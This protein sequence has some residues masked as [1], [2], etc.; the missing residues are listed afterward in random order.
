MAFKKQYQR[1]MIHQ[2]IKKLKDLPAKKTK[3][4]KNSKRNKKINN[5]PRNGIRDYFYVNNTFFLLY[6]IR[7]GRTWFKGISQYLYYLL[8]YIKLT[9]CTTILFFSGIHFIALIILFI[10]AAFIYEM[11][12][13][14]L[15]KICVFFMNEKLL[16]KPQAILWKFCEL[17][18]TIIIDP[19]ASHIS[20]NYSYDIPT[21][22]KYYFFLLFFVYYIV[23]YILLQG[24]N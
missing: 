12:T 9:L 18:G 22:L 16:S 4:H 8:H 21:D 15:L 3:N 24:P 23:K 13:Y 19:Q 14:L 7:D 11:A 6:Y 2:G 10:T 1:L 20:H 5:A 17:F